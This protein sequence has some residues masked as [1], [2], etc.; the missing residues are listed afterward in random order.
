MARL[1]FMWGTDTYR[2]VLASPVLLNREK[3]LANWHPKSGWTVGTTPAG[4]FSRMSGGV[5]RAADT[6]GAAAQPDGAPDPTLG[7]GYVS[8]RPLSGVFEAGTWRFLTTANAE[9][10]EPIT[11]KG[12]LNLR[13]WKTGQ[14]NGDSATEITVG[15]WVTDEIEFP[16]RPFGTYIDERIPMPEVVMDREYL[17]WQIAW[18]ITEESA[19][20]TA[21]VYLGWGGSWRRDALVIETS[22]FAPTA[23][24]DNL[25]V[26]V[27][28]FGNGDFTDFWP[29]YNGHMGPSDD[30]THDICGPIN[31]ERG[32]DY[33]GQVAGGSKAG[34]MSVPLDNRHGIYS[35]YY[36]MQDCSLPPTGQDVR[37]RD[38]KVDKVI[39][40]GVL[41]NLLP[42]SDMDGT[43]TVI[44]TAHG[45]I[46][47]L[48]SE[49]ITLPSSSGLRTDILF[50]QVMDADDI[51]VDKYVANVGFVVAGNVLL[52]NQSVWSAV[53]RIDATEQG[54]V[55]EDM[56]GRI[57]FEGR[58]YRLSE[59]RCIVPQAE[60]SSESGAALSF[61]RI[62]SNNM[63]EMRRFMYDR[64]RI[65]VQTFGIGQRTRV[66]SQDIRALFYFSDLA[67]FPGQ[68]IELTA[69]YKAPNGG[70]ISS[71]ETPTFANGGIIADWGTGGDLTTEVIETGP[72]TF[73][74]A[75][76]NTGTVYVYPRRVDVYGYPFIINDPTEVVR[77]T[78]RKEYPFP[79]NLYASISDAEQGANW[80]LDRNDRPRL[81][82]VITFPA[83]GSAE[84]MEQATDREISDLILLTVND[85]RIQLHLDSYPCYL[86]KVSQV[87]DKNGTE[88]WC[89]FVLSAVN[90]L[91]QPTVL[92]SSDGGFLGD[93]LGA[94]DQSAA[95]SRVIANLGLWGTAEWD[96]SLWVP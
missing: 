1:A 70:F 87:S 18:E 81:V 83:H 30:V 40:G 72:T 12:R 20:P 47:E 69:V 84:L 91:V 42:S 53:L 59:T 4:N 23:R 37:I 22:E 27:D 32:K 11:L 67:M 77:G 51:P 55:I 21:G 14:P 94:T 78:G 10:S 33:A 80:I 86:E 34:S 79:G 48:E 39:W 15:T 19:D 38:T 46:T 50:Q 92:D 90:P 85:A 66:W 6:F 61:D 64:V 13:I 45:R 76:T 95:S 75:I 88:R 29:I 74:F 96:T 68:R 17:Y 56:E 24:L 44:L 8:R 36:V 28:W 57:V 41:E 5:I 60:F 52:E 16:F 82:F 73:R 63:A 93:I 71:W 2:D 7:D 3:P 35:P 25:A 65:P 43:P 54:R 31:W 89:T 62:E 26:E 9:P 58:H 49:F